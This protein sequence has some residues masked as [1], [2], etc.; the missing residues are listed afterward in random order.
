M[1]VP[2]LPRVS[3]PRFRSAVEASW[4]PSTAYLGV[5]QP[6]NAALGQC[7]PTARV[8]QWFFPHLE[9]VSGEVDTGSSLE[10][11]FWNIDPACEPAEHVDFTWHQFPAGAKVTRFSILDRHALNDSAPTIL[12]CRL[13]LGRVLRQL[14][15]LGATDGDQPNGGNI[16]TGRKRT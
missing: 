15:Q 11:H 9:I 2:P 14:E 12:R 13:L 16:R 10:A 7:Y 6:G 8:V 4:D 5:S 1:D 3:L